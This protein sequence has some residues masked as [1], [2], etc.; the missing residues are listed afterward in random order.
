MKTLQENVYSGVPYKT[1][2]I[3]QKIKNQIEQLMHEYEITFD[4]ACEMSL[5]QKFYRM[6]QE[7]L[8]CEL[9]LQMLPRKTDR[10]TSLPDNLQEQ[11]TNQQI[12]LDEAHAQLP[13][14]VSG[15]GLSNYGATCYFNALISALFH[16]PQVKQML[17]LENDTA[18]SS[19]FLL[20]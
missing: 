6:V 17:W 16:I 15:T 14:T 3:L 4:Q 10:H 2:L 9:A 12:T 8:P 5:P 7:G 13:A 1:A 11:V 18:L 19:E 20:F